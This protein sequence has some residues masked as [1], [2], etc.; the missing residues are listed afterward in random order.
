MFPTIHDWDFIL[1]D[2]ITKRL[3]DYKRWDIVV[4][5]PPG[6]TDPYVKRIIWLPGESVT[7]RD[8]TVTICKMDEHNQDTEQCSELSE[9]FL[10]N[11]SYTTASCGRDHFIVDKGY[12][13]MGDNRPGSTD[14]RCCFWLQCFENTNYLVPDNY[15]IGKVILRLYPDIGGFSNPFSIAFNQ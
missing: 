11:D 6:K 15:I 8:N 5:L 1:V 3:H 13:V 10:P 9:D 7:I 2:K 14:S 12:F 4:F